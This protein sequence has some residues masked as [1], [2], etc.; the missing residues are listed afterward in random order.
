[1]AWYTLHP[2]SGCM[3][4][5]EVLWHR[6]WAGNGVLCGLRAGRRGRSYGL[7]IVLEVRPFGLLPFPKEREG[8]ILRRNEV[9]S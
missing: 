8:D 1:M 2:S 9:R 4:K 6:Q 3:A 7:T 5:G